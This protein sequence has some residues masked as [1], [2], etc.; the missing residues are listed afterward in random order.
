MFLLVV[1]FENGIGKPVV[2]SSF[3]QFR[4]PL[5]RSCLTHHLWCDLS[6]Q[7]HAFLS[8]ISL[9]DLVQRKDVQEVALRQDRKRA[10][11]LIM[12]TGE[13]AAAERKAAV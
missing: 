1:D 5:P 6:E 8:N 11:Q 13:A 12:S 4:F 3:E 7:I 10:D 2:S 9:F